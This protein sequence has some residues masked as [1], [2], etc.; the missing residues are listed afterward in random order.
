MIQ[1]NA[2]NKP[3]NEIYEIEDA[4]KHEALPTATKNDFDKNI[5]GPP[6]T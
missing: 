5:S 1:P 2:A 4:S 6:D 3:E